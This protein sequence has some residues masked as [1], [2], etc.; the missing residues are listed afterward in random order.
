M[1]AE[2]KAAPATA[3]ATATKPASQ[4]T[5]NAKKNKEAKKEKEK[6]TTGGGGQ[7]EFGCRLLKRSIAFALLLLLVPP[8]NVPTVFRLGQPQG[9]GEGG[10]E[11]KQVLVSAIYLEEVSRFSQVMSNFVD[12]LLDKVSFLAEIVIE[13]SMDE[14]CHAGDFT[15]LATCSLG[16]PS[17]SSSF[18][19]MKSMTTNTTTTA[20][21]KTMTTTMKEDGEKEDDGVKLKGILR[22]AF[23]ET[24]KEKENE[25][26]RQCKFLGLPMQNNDL[27]VGGMAECCYRY[28]RCYSS[29]G[30]VKLQCD[31]EFRSCLRSI[32]KQ[33]FD[34][35]NGTLLAEEAKRALLARQQSEL[36]AADD[37][38]GRR[39]DLDA[40]SESTPA[41]AAA[42]A[43]DEAG[44]EKFQEELSASDVRTLKD[45]YRACRLAGKL[46]IVGNL[47]FGCRNYKQRQWR[48]CCSAAP[49]A[50]RGGFSSTSPASTK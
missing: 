29:C 19:S 11:S 18:A 21:A 48:A 4:P 30:Q 25:P 13:S 45:K 42:A 38:D 6:K 41:A 43:S 49:A 20:A 26:K 16:S 2:A 15:D 17:S 28:E 5:K 7:T 10:A 1:A 27:P 37:D 8:L 35:K 22:E 24:E 23:S 46:L 9:E 14:Q 39:D 50:R 34:H 40:E 3:M 31:T 33:K 12:S 47:A 32:C 44:K 36:N